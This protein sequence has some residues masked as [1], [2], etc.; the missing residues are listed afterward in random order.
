M[1]SYQKFNQFV[2][3]LANGVHNFGSHTLKVL[4]TNTAPVAT[5]SVK[6]DLTEISAGSG[7]SAGGATVGTISDTDTGGTV[8]LVASS[9]NTFTASG[10][11]IGPFRY[12]V[13][14]N[15][16]PTSP[17]D[18]L[19]GFWDYGSSIT[20]ADGESFKVDWD[21]TNGIWQLT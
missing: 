15:D 6:A 9:D 14:Y 21:Q 2:G 18:P 7:Y 8:K 17:A 20:L 19:I 16:T 5:N 12:A 13:L 10:G 1:A 4:L 11:T 3:D